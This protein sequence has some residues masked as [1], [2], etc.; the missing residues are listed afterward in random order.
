MTYTLQAVESSDEE[1]NLVK[2]FGTGVL[3]VIGAALLGWLLAWNEP[4]RLAV[5]LAIL[6]GGA[7]ILAFD[8][9]KAYRSMSRHSKG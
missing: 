5:P 4:H 9:V 6:V 3:L 7:L 8:S 2:R 1:T